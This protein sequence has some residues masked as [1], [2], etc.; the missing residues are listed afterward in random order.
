MGV[1]NA[2]AL[3]DAVKNVVS[4]ASRAA[5]PALQSIGIESKLLG[6]FGHP[7]RH[8]LAEN[9]FSQAPMRWR[10]YIAKLALVPTSKTLERIGESEI[11]ASDDDNAF[12]HSMIDHFARRGAKFS[13]MVQ[14]CTDLDTMPVEDASKEWP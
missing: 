3:P 7:S 14:L 9:Y 11:D 1:S 12:R 8:P 4:S 2:P 10:D 13:L 5:N 6:F